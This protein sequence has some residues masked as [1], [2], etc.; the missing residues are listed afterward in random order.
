MRIL[1]GA[2]LGVA[3]GLATAIAGVHANECEFWLLSTIVNAFYLFGV[4]NGYSLRGR[5]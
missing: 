3:W 1:V 2:L 5:P 4:W